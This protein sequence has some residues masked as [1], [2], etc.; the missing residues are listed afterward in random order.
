MLYVSDLTKR[1][2]D[3]LLFEHVNLIVNAGDRVGLVGPNGSGKTTLLR[4]L[5]GEES[6]D[7]G[8]V[9]LDVPSSSVG[10]LRQALVFDKGCT[11]RQALGIL[12]ASEEEALAAR[13]EQLAV[14]L[15]DAAARG[16]AVEE[17]ER[18]YSEVLDQLAHAP[19]GMQQYEIERVL[20]GLGLEA[21][22]PSTPVSVL[23]GGQKTRLGLAR[24]LIEQPKLLLLDE[25][26][27]HLDITGLEWLED[28]L[29]DYRGALL[30]VSHD[31]AFLDRTVTLV[32]EIDPATHRGQLYSG[33]YT[34]YARTKMMEREKHWQAYKEQ[35]ERI[36]QLQ[37]AV[38]QLEGQARN[39]E[40]ETIDFY[41]RKRAKKVARQAVVHRKRIERMLESEDHLEKPALGWQMKLG[42][43]NTPPSGQDVL[44]L[45]GVGKRFGPRVLLR[46]VY[47]TLRRGERIVVTGP[48][49]VGKTTLLRIIAG[50]EEPSWG[51][52][53]L[54]SNVKIG[55]FSQEQELLDWRATPLELVRRA[56]PLSET[57]ARSFLHFLLFAGDDV[58][59]T[60]KNLSYGQRSRLALGVLVLQ[61]CN[62]LLLDEPINH[63]D[64][65]SRENFERALE[66][67]EGTV[68][69]VVHD[70]YFAEHFATG[71][72][73]IENHTVQRYIDLE[74]LRRAKG[75]RT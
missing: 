21:I 6:A 17:I 25:P 8:S 44:V 9:R 74:D 56:A 42:F 10:Y 46:D 24:L 5:V 26:T 11:V 32:L 31:R 4:I 35:Q 3:T 69:A 43:V 13:L 15:A 51:R 49:G 2:G 54:G 34:D 47:L 50:L 33:T 57:E 23:S 45:E 59:M 61:G 38:K 1:Y 22:S 48:N 75:L 64:I 72:W 36:A 29:A 58:F 53:K 12:E 18:A 30:V 71:I 28:Y 37:E 19:P 39:I 73:A 68:L 65:P 40:A 27:N 62:L 41:W 14:Q 63:L 70:R 20:H 52:V 7:G 60:V 55:F 16:E 66:A 67:F